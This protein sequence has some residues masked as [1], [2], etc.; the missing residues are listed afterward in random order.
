MLKDALGRLV[1]GPIEVEA[2]AKG[3]QKRVRLQWTAH[4]CIDLG[5][6]DRRADNVGYYDEE[7]DG[8]VFPVPRI[9]NHAPSPAHPW[10]HHWTG[11]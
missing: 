1:E 10:P 8:K 2:G 4:W 3:L 5:L 9:I 6:Y 7:V 11:E